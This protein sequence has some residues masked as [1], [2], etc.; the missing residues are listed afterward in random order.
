MAGYKLYT[1]D[2]AAAAPAGAVWSVHAGLARRGPVLA[3][4]G[5]EDGLVYT[6]ETIV[7]R[8]TRLQQPT[9]TAICGP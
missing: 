1:D 5:C 3:A 9:P 2:L 7:P 4:Y 6:L 8:D